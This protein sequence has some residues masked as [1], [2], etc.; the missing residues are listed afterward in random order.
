MDALGNIPTVTL[1]AL[2]PVQAAAVLPDNFAKAAPIQLGGTAADLDLQ[3]SAVEAKRIDILM[4]AARNAPQPLGSQVFT[5]F[6][7]ATGQMITRFRDQNTGKV[8]YI[9]EP[10]LL[11]MTSSHSSA[12][13]N[14]VNINI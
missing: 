10:D 7:D 2:K 3:A 5:M 13:D 6:K 14:L 11:S 8:T 1:P 12:A 4:N 9:P